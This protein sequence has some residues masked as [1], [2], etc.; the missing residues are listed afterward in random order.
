MY[1]DEFVDLLKRS[2]REPA[3]VSVWMHRRGAGYDTPVEHCTVV[4]GGIEDGLHV[5]VPYPDVPQEPI[6]L[7][8]DEYGDP[9]FDGPLAADGWRTILAWL[10][11]DGILLRNLELDALMEGARWER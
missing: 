4:F 10:I 7:W 9:I 2:A 3:D 11:G 8:H 5:N 1:T 6:S